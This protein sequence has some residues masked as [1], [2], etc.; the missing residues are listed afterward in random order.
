MALEIERR[1]LVRGELWRPYALDG[2]VIRQGYLASGNEGPT[3]RVR[4]ARPPAGP[5]AAFLTLKLPPAGEGLTGPEHREPIPAAGVALA[6]EEYEYA[7]PSSDAEALLERCPHRVGKI[8]YGLD[9]P[10]GDWVLDVFE[11]AN[12]PLVVAEVELE[13]ADQPVAVPPWCAREITGRRELSNAALARYPLALW[14]EADR[15]ALLALTT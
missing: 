4:L 9:L 15:Q 6:R 13:R 8:R 10:G 3:L 1:F 7:I 14:L 12:A 2:S 11:G 5:V